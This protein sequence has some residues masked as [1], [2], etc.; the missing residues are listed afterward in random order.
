ML[1][2]A[3]CLASVIYAE[4]RG[5]PIDGQIAVGQVVINRVEDPRW[6]DDIC[7]VVTDDEQF[8]YLT[9]DQRTLDL[10]RRIINE[11]FDDFAEGATHFYSGSEPWWAKHM[12]LIGEINGHTFMEGF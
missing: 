3:A 1:T 9:P 4:A 6:P 5:E 2:A 10:A 12:D 8:A 11:D 7:S